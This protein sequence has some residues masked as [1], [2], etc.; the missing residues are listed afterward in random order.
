MAG[1]FGE[2][3][4]EIGAWRAVA[5]AEVPVDRDLMSG[6]LERFSFSLEV[7]TGAGPTTAHSNGRVEWRVAASLDR[8]GAF[9]GDFEATTPLFVY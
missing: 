1:A 4:D 8:K 3:S 2:N 7:P 6:S 5:Q 9:K